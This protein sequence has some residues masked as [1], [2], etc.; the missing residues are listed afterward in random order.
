[1]RCRSITSARTYVP[2]SSMI[3][4][5]PAAARVKAA[6]RPD[7]PDPTTTTR[8]NGSEL[9]VRACSSIGNGVSAQCNVTAKNKERK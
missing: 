2:L 5:K 8:G 6:N 9:C 4:F 3:G 1:M 7:G